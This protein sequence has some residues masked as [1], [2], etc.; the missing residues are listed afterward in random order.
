M[1]ASGGA[2][3]CGA[4]PSAAAAAVALAVPYAGFDSGAAVE[5]SSFAPAADAA[6]TKMTST[7]SVEGA[8]ATATT[9]VVAQT[10]ADAGVMTVTEKTGKQSSNRREQLCRVVVAAEG[11]VVQFRATQSNAGL[12]C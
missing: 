12:T 9:C 4:T 3:A 7:A 5:L 6:A 2:D 10:G 8:S 1:K 11:L